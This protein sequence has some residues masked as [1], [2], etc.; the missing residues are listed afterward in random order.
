ML[1]VRSIRLV[2]ARG[3]PSGF[4][5]RLVSGLESDSFKHRNATP[6]P[7]R[8]TQRLN[9]AS[10]LSCRRGGQRRV[11]TGFPILRLG[12]QVRPAPHSTFDTRWPAARQPRYSHVPNSKIGR[13]FQAACKSAAKTAPSTMLRMVPLP[14]PLPRFCRSPRGLAGASRPALAPL[15]A[16]L[17]GARPAHLGRRDAAPPPLASP[18]PPTRSRGG[19]PPHRASRDARLSTGCGAVEGARAACWNA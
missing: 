13:D 7:D 2:T 15:H 3:D 17:E 5:M 10:E 4:F 11:Q 14:L 9:V 8:T 19:G 18:Y 1:G 12:Q 6:Y 16:A